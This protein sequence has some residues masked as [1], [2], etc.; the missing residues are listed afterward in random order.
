MENS[1]K[2]TRKQVKA[3][4]E[5]TYPDYNGRK[6]TVEAAERVTFYDTNWSGGTRSQY[7]A[8][9]RDGKTGTFTAPAPWVNR[10][11]GQ[12]V[13][14]PEDVIIVKHSI[15]CGQDCGIRFYVHPNV[16]PKMLTA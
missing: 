7:V 8:M 13:D 3:I 1:F 4:I 15:F 16:M 12:T 10:L 5:Q 6:F 11:E 2:V 14:L 9:T